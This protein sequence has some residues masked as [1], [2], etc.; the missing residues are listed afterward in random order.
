MRATPTI[1]IAPVAENSARFRKG[2][3]VSVDYWVNGTR[4]QRVFKSAVEADAW[5]ETLRRPWSEKPV[6]EPKPRDDNDL[7][8]SPDDAVARL[9]SMP[10]FSSGGVLFAAGMTSNWSI[11]RA[12][13]SID[14]AAIKVKSR[15]TRICRNPAP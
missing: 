11:H 9:G 7:V 8:D 15:Q 1:R 4:T 13:N 14:L 12:S 3:R 2:Y 6:V 10:V 5:A